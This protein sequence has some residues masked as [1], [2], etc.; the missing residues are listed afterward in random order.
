MQLYF[1]DLFIFLLAGALALALW[2]VNN[3][4]FRIFVVV[5][6]FILMALNPVRFKEGGVSSIEKS[7]SMFDTL[8]ERV[9]VQRQGFEE[10]QAAEHKQLKIQ[11]KEV[12][13]EN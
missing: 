1:H 13:N 8:P 4:K 10:R 2:K 6:A 5:M 11:S 7:V 3:N 12:L 9:E